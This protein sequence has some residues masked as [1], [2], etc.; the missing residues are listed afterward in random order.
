MRYVIFLLIQG[1]L[2]IRGYSQQDIY[3]GYIFPDTIPPEYI[4]DV[5][6]EYDKI[7]GTD[8]PGVKKRDIERYAEAVSY[9]KQELFTSGY[10]Y[11]KWDE[12]ETYL[13]NVLQVVLP[14]E[15]KTNYHI[16]I[17]PTRDAGT[18]AFTIY[19]GSIFLN[20]GL[21][22]NVENEAALAIIIGHEISHFLN[23]DVKN[24]Y[25]K[26]LKLYTR[27]NRNNNYAL[28]LNKAKFDR[29]TESSA[30]SLGFIL[31][32]NAGYDISYGI[33]NYLTFKDIEQYEKS[34]QKH[35]KLVNIPKPETDSTTDITDNKSMTDLL[36]S[37]PDLTDRIE[38]LKKFMNSPERKNGK[39]TYQISQETFAVLQKKAKLEC[40]NILLA[41]NKFKDCIKESFIYYLTDPDE[42][43]YTYYILEA[44]RRLTYTDSGEKEKEFLTDELKYNKKGNGI[45]HSLKLLIPDDE[46]FN[47]IS[48]PELLD[49]S[50]YEFETYEQAFWYFEDVAKIKNISESYLTL[51]LH[52]YS[53]D[54]LCN[55]YL[56]AYLDIPKIKYRDYANALL[57]KNFKGSLD[58]YKRELILFDNITFLEDHFYGYHYRLL[59]S[60]KKSP[61]YL[62]EMHAMFK[63]EFPEKEILE[64]E[65]LDYTD[66]QTKMDYRN[67]IL[68][69]TYS[70][71][72]DKESSE[73]VVYF[74]R[75]EDLDETDTFDIFILN[76][77]LWNIFKENGLR[78]I[79]YMKVMAFDDKTKI[80]KLLNIINP[81]FWYS[82]MARFYVSLLNG[83]LRYDHQVT[84]YT[85]NSRSKHCNVYSNIISYKMTRAHFLN[86]LYFAVKSL[87]EK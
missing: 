2:I 80:L 60:E 67:A 33:S 22:A 15:L 6:Q 77:N 82:I 17:Y 54:S 38:Y 55:K 26:S 39:K 75:P 20:I 31:A 58:Y 64:I 37:H 12:L 7:A 1:I 87:K 32:E 78:S 19:D 25:L 68:S 43:N 86:S 14:E 63:K 56:K 81:C 61:A 46:K 27:H 50:K 79:G 76:P 48:V 9:G 59:L 51:A 18:N 24:N 11:I 40:I 73:D 23:D 62:S 65:K 66:L 42:I 57:A 45:L 49:T 21:L 13:N 36:A 35:R 30:D 10:V 69:S 72:N 83:S 53:T 74:N 41:E 29:G 47:R 70:K 85:Y 28:K 44:L 4:F 52:Y 71:N 16:H 5:R 3:Y 84:Y 8:I 34:K